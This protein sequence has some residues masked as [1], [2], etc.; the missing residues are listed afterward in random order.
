MCES[1]RDREKDKER[2]K[3]SVRE[4]VSEREGDIERE[5]Q[6]ARGFSDSGSDAQSIARA[7]ASVEA[8]SRQQ[9]SVAKAA[10]PSSKPS[11]A[12]M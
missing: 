8:A 4:I 5:S 11:R 2:E 7:P 9:G 12:T 1:D 6:Q 3:E 10:A